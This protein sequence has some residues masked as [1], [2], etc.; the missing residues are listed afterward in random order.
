MLSVNSA[1]CRRPGI[2]PTITSGL[3]ERAGCVYEM[4]INN[5]PVLTVHKTAI[6]EEP[7]EG[8]AQ[9]IFTFGCCYYT[10]QLNLSTVG[11]G[12]R[13]QAAWYQSVSAL[14]KIF[15]RHHG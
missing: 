3:S 9:W 8:D 6:V 4:K 13:L 10:N 2:R 1:A 11:N 12:P 14:A 15:C 5:G 7:G